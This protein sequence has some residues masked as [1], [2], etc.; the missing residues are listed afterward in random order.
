MVSVPENDETV[1]LDAGL[2]Q[3]AEARNAKARRDVVGVLALPFR[4]VGVENAAALR[5]GDAD[6][7]IEWCSR[8]S[9][10][11]SSLQVAVVLRRDASG[12]C[13]C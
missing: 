7:Q 1:G 5:G 11:Q 12:A 8:A 9:S 3:L 13:R 10:L 2:D 4:L 6:H